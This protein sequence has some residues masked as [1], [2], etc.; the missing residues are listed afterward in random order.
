MNL[1][2]KIS[3]SELEIMKILWQQESPVSFTEIRKRLQALKSW[4]K[5]TINTLV[6][7]LS[8]KGVISSQKLDILYYSPNITF[9]D[10]SDFQR[11]SLIDKLY[12]GSAKKLV[13]SLC[14]RGELTGEDIDEIKRAFNARQ[15]SE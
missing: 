6:R 15:V 2:D 10:Y 1:A 13:A 8:Q 7:R 5:S 9:S 14:E 11:R 12:S 3:N 4:D